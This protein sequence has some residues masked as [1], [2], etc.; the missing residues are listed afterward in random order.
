MSPMKPNK[1]EPITKSA[2]QT[3]N[4]GGTQ[5]EQSSDSMLTYISQWQGTGGLYRYCT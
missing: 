3:E 4:S 2:Y 5:K 1:W